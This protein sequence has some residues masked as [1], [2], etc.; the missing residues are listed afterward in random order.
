MEM[1]EITARVLREKEREVVSP[2]KLETIELYRA[3][4]GVVIELNWILIRRERAEA[5][6]NA[7]REPRFQ[8]IVRYSF[9][10]G[11]VSMD[12]SFTS[13]LLSSRGTTHWHR[14]VPWDRFEAISIY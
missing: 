11:N 7:M 4:N 12:V 5:K 2:E 6:N 14:G 1:I 10:N 3:D 9:P 13:H 8:F